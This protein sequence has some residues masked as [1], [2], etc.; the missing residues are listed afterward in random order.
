MGS[1]EFDWKIFNTVQAWGI[2]NKL[3]K[4]EDKMLYFCRV[5]YTEDTYIQFFLKGK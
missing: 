2:I 1:Y 4:K 5:Q 3:A